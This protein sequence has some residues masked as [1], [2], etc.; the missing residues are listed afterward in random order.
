LPPDTRKSHAGKKAFFFLNMQLEV[1]QLCDAAS[2][3]IVLLLRRQY[4]KLLEKLVSIVS[5]SGIAISIE[6][7]CCDSLY[8]RVFSTF[9]D[10]N[11]DFSELVGHQVLVINA[12][13]T[14]QK[15]DLTSNTKFRSRFTRLPITDY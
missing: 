10:R 1:C 14:N 5:C 2:G 11:R 4:A 7:G 12:L 6:S 15:A 9:I 3:C 13:S 8:L